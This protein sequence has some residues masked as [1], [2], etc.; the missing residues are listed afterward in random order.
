M[1]Y[2]TLY[3]QQRSRHCTL[4]IVYLV[5]V[6]V[7][8]NNWLQCRIMD[9]TGFYLTKFSIKICKVEHSLKPVCKTYFSLV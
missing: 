8:R 4:A 7:T 5:E 2:C 9:T 3:L 1:Y 6:T